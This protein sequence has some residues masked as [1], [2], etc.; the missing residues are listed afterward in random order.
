MLSQK[1]RKA[2]MVSSDN[3]G[4]EVKGKKYEQKN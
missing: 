4:K 2:V 3:E 1:S